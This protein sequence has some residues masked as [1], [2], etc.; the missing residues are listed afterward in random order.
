MEDDIDVPEAI[1]RFEFKS[2]SKSDSDSDTENVGDTSSQNLRNINQKY[3]IEHN[4]HKSDTSISDSII[5][6]DSNHSIERECQ[7][8]S[9]SFPQLNGRP[10]VF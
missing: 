2:D 10:P 7:K 5:Q 1:K 8:I 6:S 4:K 9:C 3:S